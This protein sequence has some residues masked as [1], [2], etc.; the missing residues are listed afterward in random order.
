MLDE[1]LFIEALHKR[2]EMDLPCYNTLIVADPGEGGNFIMKTDIMDV[3]QNTKDDVVVIDVFGECGPEMNV[4]GLKKITFSPKVRFIDP[5]YFS[6]H[7]SQDGG[8]DS[9]ARFGDLMIAMMKS[10]GLIPSTLHASSAYRAVASAIKRMCETGNKTTPDFLTELAKEDDDQTR[11]FVHWMNQFEFFSNTPMDLSS[12]CT[13][14]GLDNFDGNCKA[15]VTMMIVNHLISVIYDKHYGTG[16]RTWVY[17][18]DLDVLLE[19]DIDGFIPQIFRRLRAHGGI[20]VGG[21]SKAS[22]SN[23]NVLFVAQTSQIYI[24]RPS[25]KSEVWLE[26]LGVTNLLIPSAIQILYGIDGVVE[27]V[28]PLNTVVYDPF[29]E[30]SVA[31]NGFVFGSPGK[32]ESLVETARKLGS[33]QPDSGTQTATQKPKEQTYYFRSCD[34]CKCKRVRVKRV[35]VRYVKRYWREDDFY[36]EKGTEAKYMCPTCRKLHRQHKLTNKELFG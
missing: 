17:I 19:K 34:I 3:L 6:V 5:L 4:F 8:D 35:L 30:E 22:L 9:V 10:M 14:I 18:P 11:L 32:G 16:K 29:K 27:F 31:N 36:E 23:N 28:A 15:A 1:N 2:R 20:Y 12:R 33:C 25:E 26:L 7:A 13:V 21:I 24:A